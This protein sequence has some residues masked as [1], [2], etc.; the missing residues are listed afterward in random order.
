MLLLLM[1]CCSASAEWIPIVW[2]DGA[3]WEYDPKRVKRSG[4]TIDFWIKGSGTKIREV[5]VSKKTE[6]KRLEFESRWA[7][8]MNFWQIH[9]N[10]SEAALIQSTS[11]DFNEMPFEDTLTGDKNDLFPITP[12]SLL[13]VAASKLCKQKK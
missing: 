7:Y 13:D 3:F 11:Y 12:D 9:C 1:I 2:V 8:S 4:N 10:S 6:S 5:L